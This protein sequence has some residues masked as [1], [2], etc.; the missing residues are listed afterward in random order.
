MKRTGVL[1]LALIITAAVGMACSSDGDEAT[2]TA[3]TEV[4]TPTVTPTTGVMS[5]TPTPTEDMDGMLDGQQLA[6][7]K[8]CLGCHTIDGS[9]LVG[10]TW[11]GLYESTVELQSG[12]TVTVDHDYLYESITDPSAKAAVAALAGVMPTIALTDDEVHAII[13]Y[14]ESL[15]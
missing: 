8:G 15:Q 14:I 3:T 6:Q 1:L 10:P 13:E 11:K 5:N 9:A 2:A 7:S 4:T 12:G